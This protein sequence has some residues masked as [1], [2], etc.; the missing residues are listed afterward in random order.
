MGFLAII[1]N[2]LVVALWVFASLGKGLLSWTKVIDDWSLKKK[3]QRSSVSDKK[4]KKKKQKV[5]ILQNKSNRGLVSYK[6]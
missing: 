3:V 2:Y 1:S 5:V 6:I 4:E